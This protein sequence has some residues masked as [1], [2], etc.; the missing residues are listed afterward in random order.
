MI[1][2]ERGWGSGQCAFI[3]SYLLSF[4]FNNS[5]IVTTLL[6]VLVLYILSSFFQ[7]SDVQQLRIAVVVG[8]VIRTQENVNATITGIQWK[9]AQVNYIC[10]FLYESVIA[11]RQL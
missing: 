8:F 11:Q 6:L 9:T 2:R 7:I 5:L 1:G 10:S 3:F 4:V